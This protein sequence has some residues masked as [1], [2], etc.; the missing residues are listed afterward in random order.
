MPCIGSPAPATGT[1]A[2]TVYPGLLRD[3]TFTR[4]NHVWVA[5]ISCIPMAHGFVYVFAI[6]DWTSRR[7]LAW[8]LPNTLTTD[9]CL[10]V[11]TRDGCW[12]DYVLVERLWKSIKYDEVYS[13]AYGIVS[14]IQQGLERYVMF[15]NLARLHLPLDG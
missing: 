13:H 1:P 14:A 8:Q 9:F 7:V 6:L 2:H 10:K 12:L 15:Y 3:L 4:S 11:L 5:D